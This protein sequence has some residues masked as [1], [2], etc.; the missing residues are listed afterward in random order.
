MVQFYCNIHIIYC[1]L[2]LHKEENERI[3]NARVSD[4]SP[5]ILLNDRPIPNTVRSRAN[6]LRV[7]NQK[8]YLNTVSYN[9]ILIDMK[10][11][12]CLFAFVMLFF[13]TKS[14]R[15]QFIK[16]IDWR[17]IY[18]EYRIVFILH[19]FSFWL[20]IET[21]KIARSFKAFQEFAELKQSTYAL[22]LIHHSK[23]NFA[24][25]PIIIRRIFHP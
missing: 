23:N 3:A 22:N 14:M 5:Q 17:A 2:R 11:I 20:D 24:N 12:L 13:I 19:K 10:H 4:L 9:K 16:H 15:H 21:M 8:T 18:N 7:L 1:K 25:F 6:S